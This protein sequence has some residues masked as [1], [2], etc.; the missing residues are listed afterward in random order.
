MLNT[1]QINRRP[2]VASVTAP[3]FGALYGLSEDELEVRA[4]GARVAAYLPAEDH[5]WEEEGRFPWAEYR[6]LAGTGVLGLT[7]PEAFGGAGKSRLGAVLF[8]EQIAARSFT[9][10]EAVHMALNGPAYAIAKVGD[11]ALAEQWVPRVISGQSMIAIAITEFEAGTALGDVATAFRRLDDGSVQIDGHKCFVT[12]GGLA[13]AML[14]VGRFGGQGLRGM[15]A[16]LV[17]C[18]D[19]GVVVEKTYR[20]LGGNAI[21]EVAVRFEGCVVPAHAVLVQGDEASTDGF[22]SVLHMY[23]TLRLGIAGICLGVAQGSV[24]RVVSHLNQR[25]QGGRRLADMQGLRWTWARLSLQVEQA[26]LL[27]YRA[28]RMVDEHGFPSARETAMAKLAASEV[29]VKASDA[30][31]Q[32]FGWRGVVRETDYPVERV[33][34]ETRGWTIAGGTTESALN[35]LAR[36]LFDV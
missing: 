25:T 19:P 13:D 4:W 29:A 27:T 8:E 31:I 14:V 20:K 22:K 30:A 1:S 16:V 11:P 26:R 36:D 17:S 18:D 6:K 3:G 10:A 15:G 7:Y 21:S 12:A 32:A 28:A 35:S 23:D 34:R 9:M 33:A 5:E 2:T 24:D